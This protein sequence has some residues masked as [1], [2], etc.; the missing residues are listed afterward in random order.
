MLETL[1]L[2]ASTCAFADDR[3]CDYMAANDDHAPVTAA[4]QAKAK[5]FF[6]K[7]LF[8]G[9]TAR[10]QFAYVRRDFVCGFVNSKNRFGGYVGWTP[11]F[12]HPGLQIGELA[13]LDGDHYHIWKMRCLGRA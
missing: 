11:F 1:L 5:A 13:E 8:E 3:V 10:W 4:Q 6:D 12:Y 9:P 7:T 2:L